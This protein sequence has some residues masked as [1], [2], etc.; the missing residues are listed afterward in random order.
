MV[1]NYFNVITHASTPTK[2]GEFFITSPDANVD[3]TLESA[4]VEMDQLHRFVQQ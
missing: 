1:F 3:S 4:G 2:R